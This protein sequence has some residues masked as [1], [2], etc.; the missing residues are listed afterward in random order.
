LEQIQGQAA[1]QKLGGPMDI[2]AF[3]THLRRM[4]NTIIIVSRKLPRKQYQAF[5]RRFYHN[6]RFKHIS[7]EMGCAYDTA[8]ANYRHAMERI[9]DLLSKGVA[10]DDK[11]ILTDGSPV[12]GDH[13]EI[14]ADTGQQKA[15]VVL[16]DDERAK[17]F[18]RPVRDTY[19]HKVC[20]AD[21]TMGKAIAETY[22]RDPYFYNGTF[23]CN[24]KKHLPLNEFVWK[25]TEEQVGS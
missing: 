21:T 14:N 11:T 10:M 19:T 23:C 5:T 7:N 12:T 17:G 13:R 25:G 2:R 24:C 22:A 1:S 20:G 9:A 4:P 6:Q 3:E 16:S 8:K 18:V 15:Y